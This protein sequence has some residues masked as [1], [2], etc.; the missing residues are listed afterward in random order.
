MVWPA[1]EGDRRGAAVEPL[2]AGA[3]ATV[4]RNPPLYAFLTLVD[5]LRIGRTR[6]R[7]RA[8][9]LLHERLVTPQFEG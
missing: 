2:Y 9:V 1:V 4:G 5:A 8:R 3:P 6:E 7:Q